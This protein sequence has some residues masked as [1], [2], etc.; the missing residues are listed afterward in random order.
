MKKQLLTLFGFVFALC[1]QAQETETSVKL[2]QI[3]STETNTK[4]GEYSTKKYTFQDGKILSIKTSDI[5][6]SFFYN[7]NG[8]LDR[9]VREN[10]MSDW[11]EVASYFYDDRNNLI[12][13]VNEYEEGG[14]SVSKTITYKY[15]GNKIKAITKRSNSSLKFVQW[16]DY[17]LENGRIVNESERDI[18]EKVISNRRID[19]IEGDLI[20]YKGVFGDRSTDSYDYDDKFSAMRLFVQNVFGKNY[21]TIVTL[22]APH[23]KEFPLESI[24]YHNFLKFS[25]TTPSKKEYRYIYTYNDLNYP[26][27]H[28]EHTGLL[29][30]IV[31]YEYE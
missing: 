19:Y 15:E 30:T 25:S 13:Y 5:V 31:N 22:I 27:T 28:I 3:T 17:T 23:E 6:Q 8:Y 24:S 14:K 12:K 16:I 4:T 29:K 21:K 10:E 20:A 2:K 26:K 1:V 11:R 7:A 18:N 9:T